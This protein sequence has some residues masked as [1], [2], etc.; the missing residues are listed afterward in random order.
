[1]TMIMER[2]DGNKNCYQHKTFSS[3]VLYNPD[4]SLI[5]YALTHF[6]PMETKVRTHTCLLI[7]VTISF[8]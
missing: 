3:L 1:M 8:G 5:V 7:S 4:L 2:T 6:V